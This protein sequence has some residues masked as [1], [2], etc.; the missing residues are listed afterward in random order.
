MSNH[1]EPSEPLM[2][3]DPVPSSPITSIQESVSS[4][5]KKP[6]LVADISS[7]GTEQKQS[8]HST[9]PPATRL[10]QAIAACRE[11]PRLLHLV[12]CGQPQSRSSSA[13]ISAWSLEEDATI[14]AIHERDGD[15]WESMSKQLPGRTIVMC[16]LRYAT[17]CNRPE[18]NED[19][20]S[21]IALGY[22]RC[23]SE[24]WSQISAAVK[25]PERD[26]EALVWQMG[27]WEIARR[28]A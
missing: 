27:R 19:L 21:D 26:V 7:H 5:H 28:A 4:I 11:F 13:R 18:W 20:L 6:G 23:K 3:D 12:D 24:L 1:E 8:E 22:Q 16:Q 9:S 15:N 25:L 14:L 10:G 17:L 2:L